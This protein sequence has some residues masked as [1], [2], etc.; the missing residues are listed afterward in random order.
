MQVVD[1]LLTERSTLQLI[2]S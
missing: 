1:T 2:K